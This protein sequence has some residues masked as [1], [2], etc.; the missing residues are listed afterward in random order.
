MILLDLHL[1]LEALELAQGRLPRDYP[2]R[3][4]AEKDYAASTQEAT[5]KQIVGDPSSNDKNCG[6]DCEESVKNRNRTLMADETGDFS[7]HV[8]SLI[9]LSLLSLNSV[10]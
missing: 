4:G 9:L 7:F 3:A 6:S 8:A 1:F 5:C 10:G 2:I